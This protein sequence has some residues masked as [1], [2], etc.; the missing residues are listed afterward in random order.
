MRGTLDGESWT[1]YSPDYWSNWSGA[2]QTGEY[3]DVVLLSDKAVSLQDLPAW[4][5]GSEEE[6]SGWT[7]ESLAKISK[8]SEFSGLS[9]VMHKGDA[10]VRLTLGG[11]EENYCFVSSLKFDFPNQG[12][13]KKDEPLKSVKRDIVATFRIDRQQFKSLKFK[14]GD[15][16][17]G[18]V[19]SV[20]FLSM[21]GYSVDF[22]GLNAKVVIASGR[23][24]NFTSAVGEKITLMVSSV[25]KDKQGAMVFANVEAR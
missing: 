20:S 6:V 15:R 11:I 2:N 9:L 13:S 10:S 25:R 7:I 14:E 5:H 12:Q 21:N 3:E 1:D 16:L 4:F 19:T 8:D 24:N 22:A 18:V 17:F 23:K